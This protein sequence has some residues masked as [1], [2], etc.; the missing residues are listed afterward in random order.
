MA[1]VTAPRGVSCSNDLVAN[2]PHRQA[3]ALRAACRS[4][5]A[6]IGLWN[7][8]MSKLRA[9]RSVA[10]PSKTLAVKSPGCWNYEGRGGPSPFGRC[11]N[12]APAVAVALVANLHFAAGLEAT[13]D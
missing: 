7:G 11:C 6:R 3:R 8:T 5:N 1:T 10:A 9:N 13:G 2:S 4:I 12:P